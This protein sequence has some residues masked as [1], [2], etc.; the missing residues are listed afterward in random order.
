MS[1]RSCLQCKLELLRHFREDDRDRVRGERSCKS[2]RW[3]VREAVPIFPVTH[4]LRARGP[5]SVELI[6]ILAWRPRKDGFAESAPIHWDPM[7]RALLSVFAIVITII[8]AAALRWRP[9]R[10]MRVASGL[11]A[12]SLCSAVFIA[13]V[14]PQA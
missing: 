8:L 10:A 12:H 7:R 6:V 14:D 1:A 9:D 5:V 2:K 3:P 11:T 13:G 4:C